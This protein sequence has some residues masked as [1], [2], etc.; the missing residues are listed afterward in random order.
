MLRWRDRGEKRLDW[1]DRHELAELQALN[2]NLISFY[3]WL[4]SPQLCSSN[5]L[6]LPR[7]IPA[8]LRCTPK[9]IT[10]LMHEANV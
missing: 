5:F 7:F 3:S 6:L 4:F 2:L 8:E 9:S 1:R 10:V